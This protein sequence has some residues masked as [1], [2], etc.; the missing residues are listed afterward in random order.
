VDALIAE[1]AD[2]IGEIVY[3]DGS[4]FGLR[5]PTLTRETL[6]AVIDAAHRRG[7]VAVVHVLSLQGAKDAVEAGADGLAHLFADAPPDDELV[8]LV[9]QHGT[10]VIPTLSLFASMTGSSM[11]PGLASD[12][13]LDSRLE[14]LG[15]ALHDTRPRPTPD[16]NGSGELPRSMPATLRCGGGARCPVAVSPWSLRR[17][18]DSARSTAA[19]AWISVV[20]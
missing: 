11:G 8:A 7:K 17:Q 3:G 15:A 2:F 4:E 16:D 12:P 10:F 9:K 18:D 19:Q 13:R 5:L 20:S 6:R 1:G 14:R